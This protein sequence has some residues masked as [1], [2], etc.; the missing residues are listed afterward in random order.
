MASFLKKV[1]H[2]PVWSQVIGTGVFS[3]FGALILFLRP[4]SDLLSESTSINNGVLL[5][6]TIAV[7]VL[8]VSFVSGLVRSIAARKN[9]SPGSF[10]PDV[11]R[12][13]GM[14][15]HPI[16]YAPDRLD[17][18]PY[19]TRPRVYYYL[20]CALI[21]RLFLEAKPGTGQLTLNATVEAVP[22]EGGEESFISNGLWLG[23][24]STRTLIEP[25]GFVDLVLAVAR[26]SELYFCEREYLQRDKGFFRFLT[27][28]GADISVKVIGTLD[29]NVVM[30]KTFSF[31]A[32]LNGGFGSSLSQP[33]R[34]R[35]PVK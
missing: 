21:A 10:A 23:V 1:W 30:T 9:S 15:Q 31:T 22:A 32:V 24:A 19:P 35:K 7:P 26:K 29:G 3:V 25:G 2:D 16:H 34:R 5:V 11:I 20:D 28:E 13:T 6:F 18:F 27:R 8:V 12:C 14:S 17:R 4:F 33:R